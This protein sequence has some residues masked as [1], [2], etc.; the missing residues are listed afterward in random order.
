MEIVLRA[1]IVYF[2]LFVLM[3]GLKRRALAEMS[4]FEMIL[5]VTFGD[6]VQQG[7][8]QE[9]YSLTG[10]VLATGTFAFW[11]SIMTWGSWRS[12]RARR[13][14]NGVPLVLI[15]NGSV[16][17]E[18]LRLEQMPLAEVQE[19]A[20]QHG[21]DDLATVRLAVLEPSGKISFLRYDQ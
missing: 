20:R 14:L 19:A 6:I 16:V 12:N 8:T 7:I 15:D 13:L 21:I 3:R 5:L 10:V 1:T 9:D 2:L 18:T 17:D 11:I 4:P